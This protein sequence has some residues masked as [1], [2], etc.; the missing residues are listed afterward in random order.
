[1]VT[2]VSLKKGE[3]EGEEGD[4]GSLSAAFRGERGLG[5]ALVRAVYWRGGCGVGWS[6]ADGGAAGKHGERVGRVHFCYF[7]GVSSLLRT[8][9]APLH[10]HS[11]APHTLAMAEEDI[12]D[13]ERSG[14]E[15]SAAS[16]RLPF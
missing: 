3:W 11:H 13:G 15:G 16:T 4:R 14:I 6:A 8:A 10:T 12:M 2:A 5:Q 7:F 1:M 9:T